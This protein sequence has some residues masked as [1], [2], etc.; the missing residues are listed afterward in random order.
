[1]TH[2]VLECADVIESALKDVAEVAAPFMDTST[3]REALLRL[4]S[5]A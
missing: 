1:M 2:L 4:T 5:S 3:K